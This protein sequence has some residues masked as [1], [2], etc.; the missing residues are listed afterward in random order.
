MAT[1]FLKSPF[2]AVRE[3]TVAGSESP[4]P[5]LRCPRLLVGRWHGLQVVGVRVGN[6]DY[7][8]YVRS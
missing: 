8:W 5:F 1:C 6:G 4:T 2:S 3:A 7:G